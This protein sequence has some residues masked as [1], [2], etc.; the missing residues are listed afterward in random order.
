MGSMLYAQVVGLHTASEGGLLSGDLESRLLERRLELLHSVVL[1]TS[2]D[3]SRSRFRH[4]IFYVNKI[5]QNRSGSYRG[6]FT[7]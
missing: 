6:C 1:A 7:S 4:G 5:L 3:G 2:A